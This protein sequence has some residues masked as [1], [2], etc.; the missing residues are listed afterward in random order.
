MHPSPGDG[1]RNLIDKINLD[2]IK[3]SN[4][5]YPYIVFKPERVGN[6]DFMEGASSSR[7]E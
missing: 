5:K 7:T 4:R 6:D 2:D 3:P 1:A